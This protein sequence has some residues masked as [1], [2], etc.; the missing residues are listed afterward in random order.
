VDQRQRELPVDGRLACVDAT[1]ALELAGPGAAL[2]HEAAAQALGIELLNP[3][4]RRLTVPRNRSGKTVD[5]WYVVRADLPAADVEEVEGVRVTTPL[6]TVVDLC[7]VLSQ[8][9][10]V[11]A[12]DSALRRNLVD[13][14]RLSGVLLAALGPGSGALRRIPRL[15]DPRSGSV[16]E[17]LLRL[18]LVRAGLS[19]L[20]QYEIR[21]RGRLVA[22]VDF[23]WPAARLVVEADGFAFHSDRA[24]YRR[25]RERFNDLERLGW[26]VLRFTWEDVVSRPEHV[27]AMVRSCLAAAA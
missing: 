8:S 14:A 7:R 1:E 22:R 25:D 21:D 23:C 12:A 24:A 11:V 27:L 5:G 20:T 15:L 18:L 17:T 4:P 16:L 2:S 26:R 3:A 19:P 13:L 10:A 6:R 9:E